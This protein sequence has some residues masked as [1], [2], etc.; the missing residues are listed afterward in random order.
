METAPNPPGGIQALVANDLCD[1]SGIHYTG[2]GLRAPSIAVGAV[3]DS[4]RPAEARYELTPETLEAI[5]RYRGLR[6]SIT[7][8]SPLTT[9]DLD[10]LQELNTRGKLWVHVLLACVDRELAHKLDP[11]APTPRRRLQ[12]V[13][14]LVTA[15]IPVGVYALPI[16]PGINDSDT[17]LRRLFVAARKSGAGWIGVAPLFLAS[18]NR[19]RF[20]RWLKQTLPEQLPRYRRLFARGIAVDPR[21]RGRLRARVERLRRETGMPAAPPRLESSVPRQ[22]TLPWAS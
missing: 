13:R 18:A 6:V 3:T 10:L 21:W 7:T 20:L 1:P 17:E 11:R 15:G 4:Y 9:R 14:T 19:R 22:L 5:V 8:K 2:R 16:L 12:T